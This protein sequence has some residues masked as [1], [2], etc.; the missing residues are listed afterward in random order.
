MHVKVTKAALTLAFLA[1]GLVGLSVLPTLA[2]DQPGQHFN[3]LPN[4]M[5]KPFATPAADNSSKTIPRPAGA[6]P[7]AGVAKGFGMSLGNRLKCWPG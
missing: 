2:A 5:P 7:A 4:D 3:L 6:M 1:A